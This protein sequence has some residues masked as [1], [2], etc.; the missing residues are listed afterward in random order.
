M[1]EPGIEATVFVSTRR[2]GVIGGD[3]ETVI[4]ML[5]S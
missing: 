3:G 5:M 4:K 2:C 1:T